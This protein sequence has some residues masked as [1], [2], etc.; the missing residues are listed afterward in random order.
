LKPVKKMNIGI[1]MH[2]SLNEEYIYFHSSSS[3]IIH[4]K[5]KDGYLMNMRLVNY[6]IDDKGLLS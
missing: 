5:D 4:N 1:S 3:C 6:T 2:Y